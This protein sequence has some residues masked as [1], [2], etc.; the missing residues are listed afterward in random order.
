VT[1]HT[2]VLATAD[3]VHLGSA[4]SP[5]QFATG[6]LPNGA[7]RGRR[8]LELDSRHAFELSYWCGT[9]P[10]LF[11]RMEGANRTLS[12]ESL[13][14]QLNAGID[15]IEPDVLSSASGVIPEGD[16][17]PILLEVRPRL[18]HPMKPGDYFSEDQPR[19]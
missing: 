12:I 5:L 15:V 14:E 4:T 13:S 1:R 17:L 9:C 11:Q 19:T 8:Y 6:E 18:V 7:W 3:V 16:Y 10:F 2:R